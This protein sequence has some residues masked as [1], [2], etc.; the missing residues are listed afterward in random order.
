MPNRKIISLFLT[1]GVHAPMLGK[2]QHLPPLLR[3]STPQ[4]THSTPTTVPM[5]HIRTGLCLVTLASLAA[6]DVPTGLPK[7]D[8]EWNVPGKSTSISVNSLLPSGV[9]ATSDNSAF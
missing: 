4:K 1:N 6:C 3:G 2:P 7:Y 8:T 9:S 5:R